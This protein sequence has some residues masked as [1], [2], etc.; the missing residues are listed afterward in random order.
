MKM[1]N[2]RLTP[3]P[4]ACFH[5]RII[6]PIHESRQPRRCRPTAVS[7][8]TRAN[9][10][11]TSRSTTRDARH[12]VRNSAQ[13][14]SRAHVRT[15]ATRPAKL[16]ERTRPAPPPTIAKRTREPP[17]AKIHERTRPTAR[18]NPRLTSLIWKCTNE[19]R[20]TRA[21]PSIAIRQGGRGPLCQGPTEPRSWECA[22]FGLSLSRPARAARSP[23]PSHSMIDRPPL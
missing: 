13:T 16:H 20:R 21:T 2:A 10:T 5:S 11:H 9:P 6:R 15:H 14:I 3:S 17:R 8:A 23:Q 12:R 22:G 18:T 7:L 1:A 4:S 19:F